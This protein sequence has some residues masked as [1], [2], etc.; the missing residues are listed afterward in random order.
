[1]T[2]QEAIKE[3]I[4]HWE[5]M[6]E[7]AGDKRNKRG[8]KYDKYSESKYVSIMKEAIGEGPTSHDCPLCMMYH[9]CDVVPFDCPL[10]LKYGSCHEAGAN[11]YHKAH[12]SESWPE[13]VKHG[14]RLIKQLRSLL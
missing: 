6:V 5:R 11:A 1:M 3:S 10:Y 8:R 12:F 4:S 9:Y 13:F 2:E 14:K 7:W